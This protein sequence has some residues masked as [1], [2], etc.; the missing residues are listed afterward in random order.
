MAK[1][2]LPESEDSFAKKF[3]KL[4]VVSNMHLIAIWC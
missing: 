4:F 3:F 1:E 2:P